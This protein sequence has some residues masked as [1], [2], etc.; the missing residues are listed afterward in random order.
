MVLFV[1][2]VGV[3]GGGAMGSQI[4]DIMAINGKEVIIKDIS[5][6]Y[7]K[8]AR[9]NVENNLDS[10][11][12]FNVTRADKEIERIEKTNQIQLT[13]EQKNKIKETLKP[14][15]NEDMKKEAMDKVQTTTDYKE[16]NDVD[17]VIEAVLET[18]DLK[19]QVFAELDKNTPSHAILAT[20]TSSLSVTEIASATNRPEKV[21]GVHF[22]N[23]PVTLPLVE[24][25]PGMETSEETVNDMIDFMSSVRNHR[26]PMQPIKVKEVPGFLVNRILFAMMNEAY[27]CYD[28]G[29]ASMRDIDLAMK[30]GAGMPMG[31][32]EL[33]DLVGIDVIYRVEEEVRKMIGGNTMRQPSQTIRKLYHA[34]RY[35]KKTKRGFYDYR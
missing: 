11:L 29:V 17:L 1:K 4:A 26:Y 34:G 10:L 12:E 21:I 2:R 13:D 16:F 7:L 22:F 3:V 5:E 20:N 23:P 24:V 27:S 32:F 28:E 14:K 30:A 35:G 31:P 8:K 19:K 25:I 15:F 18:V 6:E 33:S 9:E